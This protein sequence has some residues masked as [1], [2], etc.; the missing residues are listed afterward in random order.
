MIVHTSDGL[1]YKLVVL[2]DTLWDFGRVNGFLEK[3]PVSADQREDLT[4]LFAIGQ[5]LKIE[6]WRLKRSVG[7]VDGPW[8]VQ[9]LEHK[10]I[11]MMANCCEM[12]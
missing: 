11:F 9:E 4:A 6:D 8:N 5:R 2:P 3:Q 1:S 7:R 12:K 10:S